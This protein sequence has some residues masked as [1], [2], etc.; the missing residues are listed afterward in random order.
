MVKALVRRC[1]PLLIIL[2]IVA[3][4]TL[5][6]R[7]VADAWASVDDPAIIDSAQ[8]FE[9]FMVDARKSN[10]CEEEIGIPFGEDPSWAPVSGESYALDPARAF[11]EAHGQ[12][13]YGPDDKSLFP[14]GNG[15]GA[16]FVTHTDI[17]NNHWTHDIN[18][19][20]T[21]D[22]DSRALLARGNFDTS[23]QANEIATLELEWENGGVP[24]FA[25]PTHGDRITVWG[26]HIWDCGHGSPDKYRTEIHPPVG[27]VVYRQTAD[28]DGVPANGRQN[29]NP[30]M[31]Y[32]D[33]DRSGIGATLPNTA[34]RNTPVQATVADVFFSSFGSVAIPNLNGC[35]DASWKTIP[36]IDSTCYAVNGK[37]WVQPLVG[38]DY[39]FFIPAPPKDSGEPADAV[40]VWDVEERCSEIPANPGNPG[41]GDIERDGMAGSGD[42]GYNIGSVT[43]NI[44]DEAREVTENG[45]R[46]IRVTVR[47]SNASNP[48]NSYVGYAKR[49]KVAWDYAPPASSRAKTFNVAFNEL[50]VW[51]DA[52]VCGN[53]GEWLMSI[54][55]NENWA[56]PVLSSG[57]DGV[58]FWE[59]G[60]IDDNA[61]VGE[62]QESKNYGFGGL[63]FTAHVAPW[64]PI[65]VWESTWEYDSDTPN[66]LLPTIDEYERGPGSYVRGIESQER[67]GAH[68]IAYTITD[69]TPPAPTAG[70]LTI[71]VPQYGPNSDTGG[72]A[73]RISGV[74]PLTL[75]GSDAQSLQFQYWREVD[76]RTSRTWQYDQTSPLEV[77]FAAAAPDSIYTIAYAPVSAD[78]IVGERRETTVQLDRT[79]PTVRVPADIVVEATEAAGTTVEYTVTASDNLPGPV[80][81]T[82][83]ISSG[84]FFLIKR[85][86]TVTCT[87]TDAVG[88]VGTNS[89]TVE[90]FSPFGYIPDFVV[91]G[92]E[93]TRLGNHATVASGN[94][95]AFRSS[96][97]VPNSPGYELALGPDSVMA[98]GSQLAGESVELDSG[99]MAGATFHVDLVEVG[100]NVA[101][102]SR[103]GYV[104]LFLG[105]PNVPS[106][107]ASGPDQRYTQSTT[108][109]AGSYGDV[110]VASNTSVTLSGGDYY[111]ESLDFFPGAELRFVSPAV[112]HVAGS[113][114]FRDGVIVGPA[115]AEGSAKDLIIYVTGADE[116]NKAAVRV[117]DSVNI[118]A[119][120]Y[121]KNGTLHM[122]SNA[123]LTGGFLGSRVDIGD[124]ATLNGDSAFDY[125]YP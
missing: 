93:W 96:R 69:I 53:D 20:V 121:A 29:Q 23:Y 124:H 15:R 17:D 65:N 116:G 28:M 66:D 35:R 101:Y 123:I 80:A 61:C 68:Q 39:S 108:L 26:N 18:V 22:K 110:V 31:W 115:T 38:R 100:S 27:W 87:A 16:V 52:E 10:L 90:V 59:E 43:C 45:Q 76:G 99:V 7:A 77:S 21:L 19:F 118:M 117:G 11:V 3:A 24:R 83:N 2:G 62:G 6:T 72:Q 102:T 33:E 84:S 119:N 85:V 63:N 95:G 109:Q 89:F 5:R 58:A 78:G 113:V 112:V 104:P 48:S 54:R 79:A 42:D 44:R 12:I 56:Y 91:L 74:T 82:C 114:R 103:D 4:G 71:G 125:A 111:F 86:T 47:A 8:G 30:W 13:F 25:F 81:P 107:A 9:N 46:G 49:W 75:T 97:G 67:E 98:Q 41:I 70:S 1:I 64:Q 88:N 55:V 51:D 92:E 32:Q 36:T 37:S 122:G 34:L 73:T 120:I 50:R 105:M 14:S 94:V 40:L 60:A 57:E 106:F